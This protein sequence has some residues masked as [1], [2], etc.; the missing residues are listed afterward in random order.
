MKRLFLV[1]SLFF[2]IPVNAAEITSKITDSVQLKVDGAAVQSTRIGA[3]Y[4]AS[5]TNIQSTSF[6]GVGGAG[7]YD[8]N[9]PGQAFSFSETIN[10]ADTPVTTQTVTNGV[11]GT[12]NLYGDSVTQVGGEKG[13][14]AGTLSP[15]G[16]PTVTAGGASV[17]PNFTRGTITATTESTTKI[18]E[19]IRQ[20]EYTT[21]TS[22]T[23]TGTNINIPGKPNQDSNYSIMTQGAPFQ[24][25]E[26]YLGPGVAKETWIDRTTETQSTTNSVS[27][28]TQ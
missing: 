8:I 1:F 28:F 25:S 15:T 11:I 17:V 19:A 27:V 9:T 13:T 7:T 12:P 3:S 6:G 16:V 5:G 10:A 2:A 14:L 23:V 21:G 22:Y 18:I 4:S 24:F 20:V 26:T